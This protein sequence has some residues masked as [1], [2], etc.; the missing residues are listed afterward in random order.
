MKGLIIAAI[1]VVVLIL[2]ALAVLAI[3]RKRRSDKL[4]EEF[5]PEYDRH[6]DRKGNRREA[7]K[8]LVDRRDR[9][10]QLNIRPLDPEVRERHA[11]QW[12]DAQ[13]RFV[14][15]PSGSIAEADRLVK[16]VMSDRGYPMNDFDERADDISV[17]HPHLVEN[18]RGAHR[19]ARASERDGSVSTE[20][21]RQA[22]LHYRE[23]FGELLEDRS[24][25]DR[26]AQTGGRGGREPAGAERERKL[27]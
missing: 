24:G 19:I 14:D 1:V 10:E 16:K 13:A 11:A 26:E 21:Q 17:D 2:L 22:M 25:G 8:E 9:R 15:D 5:G 7:E 6:V 12:Q 3:M 4:R 27:S 18:F 20:D 23:L